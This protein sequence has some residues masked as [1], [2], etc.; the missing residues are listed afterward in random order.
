MLTHWCGVNSTSH[1][2]GKDTETCTKRHDRGTRVPSVSRRKR[3]S[4]RK[5]S[6]ITKV[7]K[8]KLL[9]L[10]NLNNSRQDTEFYPK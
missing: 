4:K 5:R 2:S 6:K 7:V 3:E 1:L 10:K 8:L 9:R